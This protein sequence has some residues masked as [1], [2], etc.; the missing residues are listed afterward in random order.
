MS[1]VGQFKVTIMTHDHCLDKDTITVLKGMFL[2]KQGN[3]LLNCVI[4]VSCH[5]ISKD[6]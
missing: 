2:S 4:K 6:A 3:I 5:T 1:L